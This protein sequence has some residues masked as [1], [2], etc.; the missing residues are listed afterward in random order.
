MSDY[1]W[2]PSWWPGHAATWHANTTAD[3]LEIRL[4]VSPDSVS[5]DCR[6]RPGPGF[7]C[8]MPQANPAFPLIAPGIVATTSYATSSLRTHRFKQYFFSYVVL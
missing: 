5:C 3:Q 1:G 6:R 4:Y 2:K 7:A 8:K